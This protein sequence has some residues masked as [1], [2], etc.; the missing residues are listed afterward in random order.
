MLPRVAWILVATDI[1][2]RPAVEGALAQPRYVIGRQVVAKL[3]ALVDGAP[4]IA[5]AG[6]D[7]HPRT[8]AQAGRE[9]PLVLALR[10]EDKDVGTPLLGIVPRDVAARSDRDEHPHAVRR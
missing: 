1:K 5:G 7:R 2:K 3:V 6:S 8:V 9:H 10:R 4:K